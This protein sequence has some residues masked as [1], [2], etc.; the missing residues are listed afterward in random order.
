MKSLVLRTKDLAALC[1]ACQRFPAVE[2]VRVFG[3]RSKGTARRA[4]DLDLAISA[5]TASATEWADLSDALENAPLIYE[6]DLVRLEQTFNERLK[7]KIARDGV[8]LYNPGC[9]ASQEWFRGER[10]GN[11][12]SSWY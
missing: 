5:P 8:T 9:D 1:A 6:L 12:V 2:E 11:G 3:S 7:E 4:S 10:S